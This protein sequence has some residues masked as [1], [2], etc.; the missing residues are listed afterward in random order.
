M[1]KRVPVFVG[2]VVTVRL[3]ADEKLPDEGY[4]FDK[5]WCDS[6]APWQ[7]RSRGGNNW[8]LSAATAW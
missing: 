4:P 7:R 3:T 8:A 1:I 6:R 5:R 2:L